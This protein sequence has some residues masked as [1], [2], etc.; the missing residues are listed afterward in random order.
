MVAYPL[1]FM[2]R[3][4]MLGLTIVLLDQTVIWQVAMKTAL[5]MTNV[6]LV[7][8]IQPFVDPSRNFL[9]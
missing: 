9:E 6:I 5:V 7:G 8:T 4:L 3:R 1:Y 2:M